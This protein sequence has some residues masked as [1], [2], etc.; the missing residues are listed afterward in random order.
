MSASRLKFLIS[1]LVL[2]SIAATSVAPAT[3][4]WLTRLAREAGD[5]GGG[6][7]SKAGRLE[8]GALESAA[9]FVA[10]LPPSAKGLT[11]AAHVTQEGHWK[12][13][14]RS[15][16][17]FTAATPDEMSRVAGALGEE[18][19]A[20]A[21]LALYLSEDTIF[22]G[23]EAL[24]DLPR[25]ADLNVVV[26]RSSYPIKGSGT[27]LKAEVRPN[28][29]VELG[30][31]D[32][33]REAIFHLAR[34]LNRSSVRVLGLEPGGPKALSSVPGYDPA[35]KAALVDLVDPA[36]LAAALAKLKHQTVLLTGRI[37]GDYLFFKPST[38]AE[39]RILVS[40]LSSAAE[41]AGVSLVILKSSASRQPGGKNWLWQTISVAGLDDAMKRATFGDFLSALAGSRGELTVAARSSGMD[42]IT[43]T[44]TPSGG[45][46]LPMT[47]AVSNWLTETA[48]KLMGDMVVE[49]VQAF[50]P[51][52]AQVE[53]IDARIV[54]GIPAW[55][56]YAYLLSLVAGLIGWEFSLAWWARVW[57]PEDRAEYRGAIGYHAAR[58][59]RLLALLLLFLPIVGAPAMIAAGLAAVW[60]GLT[61]PVRW[62]RRLRGR[63]TA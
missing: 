32:M 48:G 38:G 44:A 6:V 42:R 11:L 40:E 24:K 62:W 39:S 26:E 59:V 35:T 17:V 54:P 30:A 22:K 37:D 14:N 8:L 19:A 28:L 57:P 10:K 56:Q 55:I 43:L 2:L 49:G 9:E 3:A 50:I 33:F 29:V 1:G 34:P 58:L 46:G 31:Q 13:V 18:G 52:K 25:S 45:A 27:T 5:A 4:N 7:G 23:R 61:A 51:D 47:D 63:A 36:V 53:E 21:Q 41:E 20:G 60:R 12:F 15:G 16:E